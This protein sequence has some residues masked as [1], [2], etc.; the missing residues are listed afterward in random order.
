MT[1]DLLR[2]AVAEFILVI[3]GMARGKQ[4]ELTP[5]AVGAYITGAYFFTASTSF[6]N[7]AVA[8]MFS[9]TFAGIAPGSVIA[10]VAF[11]LGAALAFG[12][13]RLLHPNIGK[14]A[15]RV[16]VVPPTEESG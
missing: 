16:V 10:F 5:F 11:Q 3:F 8:R 14:V 9:N 2:K 13:V 12:V 1:H 15:A 6:A 4:R 7:L